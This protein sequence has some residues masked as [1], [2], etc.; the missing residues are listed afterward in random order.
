VLRLVGGGAL[1]CLASEVIGGKDVLFE[2]VLADSSSRYFRKL[3]QW[4]VW[5]PLQ[6]SSALR[7][8]ESYWIGFERFTHCWS[9]MALKTSL[10][11]NLSR[12]KCSSILKA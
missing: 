5:C 11:E 8:V 3:L 10:M 9:L 6:Y 7:S 12:V 4:M 1:G 2:E